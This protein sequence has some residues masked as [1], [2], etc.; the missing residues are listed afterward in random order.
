MTTEQTL[1][2]RLRACPPISITQLSKMM[3]IAADRIDELQ[4]VNQQL[5]EDIHLSG[6]TEISMMMKRGVKGLCEDK[7]ALTS[8]IAELERQLAE[9]QKDQA[10][11]KRY[12]FLVDSG[13]YSPG[14]MSCIWGLCMNVKPYTKA[15]LDAPIDAAIAQQKVS[16]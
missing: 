15:E 7:L 16:K 8:R 6:D 3:R 5:I 10:D 13:Q 11:A 14:Y 9:A 2:E 4:A 1:Q 12:R